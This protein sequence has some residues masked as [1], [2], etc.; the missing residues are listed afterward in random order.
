MWYP[1]SYLKDFVLEMRG[2]WFVVINM[3]MI[4]F[5]WGNNGGKYLDFGRF[6]RRV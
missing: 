2:W 6:V 3:L 4:P 5:V 1:L